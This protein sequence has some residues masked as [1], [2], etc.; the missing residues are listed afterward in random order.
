VQVNSEAFSTS[1][2]DLT[3]KFNLY[4]ASGVR[5]YFFPVKTK[6]Y[7]KENKNLHRI[8]TNHFV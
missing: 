6:T 8:K 1:R 5:E 7:S 2:Y 3:E 4:E